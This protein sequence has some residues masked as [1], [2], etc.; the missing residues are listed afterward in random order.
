M[1]LAQ[2]TNEQE[3]TELAQ[4]SKWVLNLGDGKLL[5][6][7]KEGEDMNPCGLTYQETYY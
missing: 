3:S 4:F 6:T 2:T 7:M 1:P 5:T